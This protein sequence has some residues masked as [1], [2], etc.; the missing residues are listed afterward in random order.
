MSRYDRPD[1]LA[2]WTE[3]CKIVDSARLALNRELQQQAGITLAE[4]LVLCHVAMAPGQRLR[5]VDIAELLAIGKSAVTKTVDR[6]EQRGLL[7]RNRDSTD[8]RT[9]Y[10]VLTPDGAQ[11]FG[12]TQPLYA[13]TVGR[14]FSGLLTD[15]D[16]ARLRHASDRLARA[17]PSGPAQ[18][19]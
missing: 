2:A 7:A 15:K 14:Y 4:N 11:V 13:G 16:L 8:R 19:R 9:V 5:M 3:L 18:A 1:G 10:A 12:E 6:L 17:R